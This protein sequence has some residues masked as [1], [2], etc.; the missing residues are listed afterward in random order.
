ML[1]SAAPA[2]SE[3][4]HTVAAGDTLWDLAG[5]YYK[6]HYKW[7]RIAEKNPAPAVNDPDLIYPGQVI[8]IP[9][10]DSVQAEQTPAPPPAQAVK[11]E[12]QEPPEQEAEE[13]PEQMPE[14]MAAQPAEEASAPEP[15]PWRP[16]DYQPAKAAGGKVLP[17]SLLTRF[18][19]GMIGQQPSVFR[20]AMPKG[21]TPEGG[22]LD[23]RGRAIVAAQGDA[24]RVRIHGEALKGQ[25]YT[26]YRR[27]TRAEEDEDKS[28]VYVE[29]VGLIEILRK[30]S[31]EE[32][33]AV[34]LKSGD[35]I[36]DGDILKRED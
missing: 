36:Q 7:R 15:A 11:E 23:F 8:V 6:D 4:R 35:A 21:W 17:D 19:P 3:V 33:R 28:E 24:V 32:Y 14:E 31:G 16:V 1:C 30:V 2:R 26:V 20:M 25:R 9:D 18:P 5:T 27:S 34:V 12:A 29:K 10:A 22:V 13:T